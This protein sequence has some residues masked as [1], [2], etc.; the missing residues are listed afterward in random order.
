[1]DSNRLTALGI[2]NTGKLEIPYGKEDIDF[3]VDGDPTS[4]YF[5]RAAK[6]NFFCRVRD[7][8]KDELQAMFVDRESKGAWSSTDLINQWDNAQSQFPEEVWRLD[9][10]RKY[11]RTYKGIS[12]DGS[13]AGAKTPRFLEE[14]LNG[15]KK[16]QRRMFE[17]N[18]EL[19]F[20]TKYFG[21]VATSNNIMMRFNN[22]VDA[23][24]KP[25]FTL[26]ITPYS[27]MYLGV[28]RGNTT[29]TNFRAKAG[30]EY[31]VYFDGD[32]SDINLIYGAPFIQKIGD[33]SKCY[34][35]DNDFSKASRLQ[36]L[37][38]GNDDIEG[39]KNAYM[40]KLALGNNKLLEYLDIRNVTG[41]NDTID[42]S[43]CSNMLELYAQGSGAKGVVFANG[44]KIKKFYLPSIVSLTAKNLN[45]IEDFDI[46][47]YINL[48][49][50][51]VE[52]TPAID[53]HEIVDTTLN[54]QSLL[55][56]DSTKLNVI[57]LIGIDWDIENTDILDDIILL[58]GQ[59]S[60]GGETKQ[61]VLTGNVYTDSVRE[62]QLESYNKAWTDLEIDYPESGLIKQYPVTFINADDTPLLNKDGEPMI[63]YVDVN[64]FAVD[65]STYDENGNPTFPT[66]ESD[67]DYSYTFAK[68]WIVQST[69]DA[70]D[71]KT[72]IRQAIT[73]KATYTKSLRTYGIK[74]ITKTKTITDSG[75]YGSNI[76]Y[77][78][79]E[80]GIPEYTGEESA[81]TFYLFKHWDKSG[82]L[83]EGE[84]GTD[85][86]SGVKIVNAVYDKF[87][88]DETA[89]G[90]IEQN[91]NP[92]I[93]GS[94][95]VGNFKGLELSDL[96]PVHIY[97][98]TKL[99]IGN[100]QMGQLVNGSY[101]GIKEGDPYTIVVGNDVDYSDIESNLLISQETSFGNSNY[102]DTGIQL[103]DVDKDFVLAIDY[104]FLGQKSGTLL[105][106][107]DA[108][109]NSRGFKLW[110]NGNDVLF[111]YDGVDQVVTKV[112]NREMII[113]R[114]TKDVET[115]ECV[116]SIYNSDLDNKEIKIFNFNRK[117][118]ANTN[119]S[120]VL[121]AS[122]SYGEYGN[123]VDA[124]INWA[125]IWLKDLG[126]DVCESLAMWTHE[127]ID[128]N[129]CGFKRYILTDRTKSSFSLLASHLLERTK[130]WNN[131][132]GSNNDGGWAESD[133]NKLLN[134]R[135]YKAMPI[136]IRNL[137][138][139]M[140]VWG[141]DGIGSS[142]PY[143]TNVTS[144]DCYITIPAIVELCSKDSSNNYQTLP[145]YKDEIQN[146]DDDITKKTISYMVNDSNRIRTFKNG[147]AGIYWTRSP[148]VA[149]TNYVWCI[150]ENGGTKT[151]SGTQPNNSNGVLIEISF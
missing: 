91:E 46:E 109:G 151:I 150:N 80:H 9:I 149:Y 13:I 104:K 141:N 50:L 68:K 4:S 2:G 143:Y 146:G 25:N 10:Q 5:Y 145:P 45:Y 96:S 8:F 6:S 69:G 77:D 7:L 64:T 148:D 110:Y 82:F 89:N 123:F 63:Q 147:N 67:I 65:P 88:Y 66:I 34:V 3:Y 124:N 32:V 27:D 115:G 84:N 33:L 133:L 116:L 127:T 120:L 111:T 134:D 137:L 31:S 117:V 28:K 85:L 38:I 112:N 61:S 24:V 129:V 142:K 30:T 103:F 73:L 118:V 138:K 40:T 107:L 70:F 26:Y 93:N 22:P 55:P 99:G 98:L 81:N 74:Y 79:E 130:Q 144:S 114:N 62:R 60:S 131:G 126:N 119:A 44:G 29:P 37:I 16:Y 83:L 51:V 52:N 41:L 71:F 17:R 54:A 125:K 58:R 18:Q 106:C 15:R 94:Y 14:M 11:L 42:L 1:M 20:A 43:Q 23:I 105:Q 72:P 95:T 57:R 140:I 35:G 92:E 39:Y 76:A 59:N 121:G 78:Y 87:S 36:S 135:L 19:Y 48:Q 100:I 122:Y 113:V 128:L 139:P 75:L 12:V 21:T 47:S 53:T 56:E 102:K 101:E 49:T 132:T 86:E 108:Y 90:L 97:A 136:Q